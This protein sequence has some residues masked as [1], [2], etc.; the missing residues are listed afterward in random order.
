VC[1]PEILDEELSKSDN[2]NEQLNEFYSKKIIHKGIT[3]K[4]NLIK[5]ETNDYAKPVDIY[6]I[7]FA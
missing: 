3:G 2:L 1:V 6:D 4:I 7:L 5:C